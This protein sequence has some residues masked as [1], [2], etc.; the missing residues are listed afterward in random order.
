MAIT[1]TFN[2][3]SSVTLTKTNGSEVSINGVNIVSVNAT[4]YNDYVA[5][6]LPDTNSQTS[7]PQTYNPTTGSW[8]GGIAASSTQWVVYVHLVNGFYE[9]LIMGEVGGAG[10]GWANSQAGANTAVA[11]FEAIMV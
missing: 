4:S 5:P 11:A 7:V 2:G 1:V 9:K 8:S 3:T 10:S 6:F